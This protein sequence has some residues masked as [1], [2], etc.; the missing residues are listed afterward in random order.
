MGNKQNNP[1][2]ISRAAVVASAL[3]KLLAGRDLDIAY[4]D[5]AMV[6]SEAIDDGHVAPRR[7]TELSASIRALEVRQ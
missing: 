1:K 2:D 6:V 3:A 7:R 5:L 4:S